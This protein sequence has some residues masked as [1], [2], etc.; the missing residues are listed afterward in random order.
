MTT[1]RGTKNPPRVMFSLTDSAA[2]DLQIAEK[3]KQTDT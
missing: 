3:W 2:D 1:D